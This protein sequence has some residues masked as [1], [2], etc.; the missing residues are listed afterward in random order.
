M[1]LQA[2]AGLIRINF[3]PAE[4]EQIQNIAVGAY[5]RQSAKIAEEITS[6]T[7]ALVAL[8]PPNFVEGEEAEFSEMPF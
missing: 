5:E 6:S 3:T 7:P 1:E 4:C 2:E 8:P